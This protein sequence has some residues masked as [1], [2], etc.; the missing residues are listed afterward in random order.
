[1]DNLSKLQALGIG[2]YEL[3][4]EY[5]QLSGLRVNIVTAGKYGSGVSEIAG[6]MNS[7]FNELGLVSKWENINAGEEFFA[8]AKKFS[9]ALCSF[10]VTVTDADLKR[11]KE[12]SCSFRIDKDCDIL[13]INDHPALLAA[14]GECNCKKIYRSHFD[15]SCANQK[16]WSF[17][18]PYI[19]EYD[20]IIFSSPF[21]HRQTLGEVFY[22]LPSIDPSTVKN[23]FVPRE[24]AL[25][26][27]KA[28]NIPANKPIITQVGRFDRLKDPFGVI[29]AFRMVRDFI[30]CTLVLAGGHAQDDPESLKVYEE[31]KEKAACDKDI[32]VLAIDREDYKI[33]ALQSVSDIILQ[34]SLSE[35][36]GLAITEALWKN[37]PVVASD[38]GGIPYQI[39]NGKTGLLCSSIATCAEAILEIL[40]NKPLGLKLGKNGHNLV[41][42]KFLITRELKNHLEIFKKIIQ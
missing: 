36:F 39:V 41:F 17:F 8:L 15:I 1:M 20:G 22:V 2:T 35:S 37:R 42:E 21:F 12:L 32:F 4:A 11:F 40:T 3:V 33:A 13:Y 5:K 30:P 23:T 25:K 26:V 9:N 34:K 10:D 7:Y 38:I 18:K 19:E 16:L 27:L 24:D 29:D 14:A 31:V 6:R 28:F